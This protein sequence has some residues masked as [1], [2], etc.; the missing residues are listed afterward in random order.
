MSNDVFE[1]IRFVQNLRYS[2]CQQSC[3]VSQR[4]WQHEFLKYQ[5]QNGSAC[6]AIPR[7]HSCRNA[8]IKQS[9]STAVDSAEFCIRILAVVGIFHVSPFSFLSSKKKP[10]LPF[11]VTKQVAISIYMD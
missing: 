6:F 5:L 2:Y 7:Q 4:L 3:L 9:V 1:V 10:K 8:D 11:S